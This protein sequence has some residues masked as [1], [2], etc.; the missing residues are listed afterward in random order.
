MHK[1]F[2][3]PCR[4]P[5]R[6]VG[7]RAEPRLWGWDR[8]SFRVEQSPES[9]STLVECVGRCGDRRAGPGGAGLFLWDRRAELGRA[10]PFPW[11]RRAEPRCGSGAGRAGRCRKGRE[12]WAR[13]RSR[14]GRSPAPPVPS[15]PG[16]GAVAA[17][18]GRCGSR[19]RRS[20]RH[21][22]RLRA[23]ADPGEA[24]AADRLPGGL[25]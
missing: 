9:A 23:C 15:L 25:G 7:C 24:A 3:V 4:P 10:G 16:P 1:G 17:G 20:R 2:R 22:R 8:V 19:G 11:D 12:P 13:G 5:G 14:R 21:A 18:A 6:A